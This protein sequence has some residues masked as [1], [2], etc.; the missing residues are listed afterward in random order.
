[1]YR[2]VQ[3]FVED[4]GQERR[5]VDLLVHGVWHCIISAHTNVNARIDVG[6]CG[7]VD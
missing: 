7:N 6:M 4:A 2:N 1:M 3:C 5:R